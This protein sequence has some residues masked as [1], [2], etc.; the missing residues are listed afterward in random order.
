MAAKSIATTT[1][2]PLWLVLLGK[3]LLR[4]IYAVKMQSIW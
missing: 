1:G 2:L 3:G 4:S